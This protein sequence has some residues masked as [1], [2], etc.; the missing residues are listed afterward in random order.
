ML[1]PPYACNASVYVG[2]YCINDLLAV[3]VYFQ[4]MIYSAITEP[5][6]RT[7]PRH[8]LPSTPNQRRWCLQ[9][10]H[11]SGLLYL[12]KG[13][14]KEHNSSATYLEYLGDHLFPSFF[15]PVSP[16]FWFCTQITMPSLPRYNH[17]RACLKYSLAIIYRW[18]WHI[19]RPG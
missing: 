13:H 8:R 7:Q 18:V 5:I 3:G 6:T 16:S 4:G 15:Y 19:R 17:K 12:V 11:R 1:W 14:W 9:V 10:M 2:G